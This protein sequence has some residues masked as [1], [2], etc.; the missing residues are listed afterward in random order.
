MLC[1]SD[2]NIMEDFSAA[3]VSIVESLSN[4]SFLPKT[5]SPQPDEK[6]PSK[7]RKSV[8]VKG[9]P[10]GFVLLESST[11]VHSAYMDSLLS[12]GDTLTITLLQ[13]ISVVSVTFGLF[14]YLVSAIIVNTWCHLLSEGHLSWITTPAFLTRSA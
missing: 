7:G 3:H 4:L 10:V 8:D 11:D 2:A 12:L 13:V 9:P 1:A 5:F 6:K 14:R